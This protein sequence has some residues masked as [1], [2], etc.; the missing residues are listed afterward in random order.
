MKKLLAAA[1]TTGLLLT[2]GVIAAPSSSASVQQSAPSYTK[3]DNLYYSLIAADNPSLRGLKR[4]LI[5]LGK[6][7][8]R[9]MRSGVGVLDLIY[10]GIDSGFTEDEV[11]SIL[12]G[13]ITFYCPDQE[14]LIS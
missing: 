1:L 2:G 7:S 8:C 9:A 6:T 10:I 12:A 11:I 3:K 13:A 14:Y 5:K 4:D